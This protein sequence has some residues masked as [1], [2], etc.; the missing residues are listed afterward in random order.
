MVP[1]FPQRLSWTWALGFLSHYPD[2]LKALR[3]YRTLSSHIAFES[4]NIS[5]RKTLVHQY[6]NFKDDRLGFPVKM[7][8]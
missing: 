2:N 8:E 6:S 7:A 3:F 1:Y 5:L 4:H